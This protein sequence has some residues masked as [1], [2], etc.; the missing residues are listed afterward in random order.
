MKPSN[1]GCK[2]KKTEV[3]LEHV[4]DMPP[5]SFKKPKCESQSETMEKK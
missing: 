3:V 2:A 5:N 4:G 1:L